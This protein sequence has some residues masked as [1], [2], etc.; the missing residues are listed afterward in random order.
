MGYAQEVRATLRT[1]A[2]LHVEVDASD[3]KMQKKVREAQLAQFNYILVRGL[4]KPLSSFIAPS[5]A[6]YPHQARF[7]STGQSQ[8]LTS[9]FA[10]LLFQGSGH[11]LHRRATTVKHASARAIFVNEKLSQEPWRAFHMCNT[12]ISLAALRLGIA[13][14]HPLR[15]GQLC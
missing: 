2:K 15:M 6:D 5:M 4:L 13:L 8:E 9:C 11:C 14:D 7:G 1:A 3:K 10:W 12:C